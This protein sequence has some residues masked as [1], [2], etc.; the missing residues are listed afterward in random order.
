MIHQNTRAR[1][2]YGDM[3]VSEKRRVSCVRV[4]NDLQSTTHTV[5]NALEKPGYKVGSTHS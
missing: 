5:L 1:Y 4:D 2:P 3:G